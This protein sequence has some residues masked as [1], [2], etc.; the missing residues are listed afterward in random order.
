M[1]VYTYNACMYAHTH[2]YIYDIYIYIYT[3]IVTYFKSGGSAKVALAKELSEMLD[4]Q[5]N[6]LANTFL[7]YSI[8]G[9][10]EK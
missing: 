1:Y 7:N 9:I 10:Y 8:L 3:Y 2:T 6:S 4:T 5:W